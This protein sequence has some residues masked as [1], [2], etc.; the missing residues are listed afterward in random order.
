MIKA[1]GFSVN[2]APVSK[3]ATLCKTG[4]VLAFP[5]GDNKRKISVVALGIRRG[6]A[7]EAVLLYTDLAPPQKRQD[8][9]PQNPKFEGKGRPT[10]KQRRAL[11]SFSDKS[12]D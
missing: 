8:R 10:G 3:P 7:S 2:G 4:D 9:V 11:S 6:P 5:Q 1:V 12:L